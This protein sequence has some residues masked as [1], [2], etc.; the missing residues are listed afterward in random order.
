M[1][2]INENLG[3]ITEEEVRDKYIKLV[4]SMYGNMDAA[5][6]YLSSYAQTT[7]SNT[8]RAKHTHVYYTKRKIKE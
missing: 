3:F 7:K 2:G 4:R 6:R 1:A 8:F 5:L